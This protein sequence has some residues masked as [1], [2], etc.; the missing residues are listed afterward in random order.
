[1]TIKQ[2]EGNDDE[3]R[4]INHRKARND[5]R[6]PSYGEFR[7]AQPDAVSGHMVSGKAGAV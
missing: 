3:R 6:S 7:Q 1:M 2:A 5:D 4:K